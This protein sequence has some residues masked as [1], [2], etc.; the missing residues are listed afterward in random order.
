M[1]KISFRSDELANG[2]ADV[3]ASAMARLN[4]VLWRSGTR[5]LISGS[6]NVG[7]FDRAVAIETPVPAILIQ[8]GWA[9]MSGERIQGKEVLL[10]TAEGRRR[11]GRTGPHGNAST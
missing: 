8:R 10:L 1:D 6:E 4:L 7:H 3:V 5:Y 9:L 2:D 11:T